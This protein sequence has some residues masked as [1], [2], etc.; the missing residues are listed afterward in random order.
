[1][2]LCTIFRLA[3]LAH[4][5]AFSPSLAAPL[6]PRAAVG[7]LDDVCTAAYAKAHL[8]ANPIGIIIDTNSV[9]ATAVKNYTV[10]E[11]NDYPAATFDFCKVTLSYS[12]D[13]G[14]AGRIITT[15]LQ[16]WLPQPS[17]F[18]N[19]WLSTGGGGLAINSGDRSLPG[20]VMRGAV[21]GITD[22]G[23]GGFDKQ[24]DSTFLRANG[25]VNWDTVYMFGYQAH[26]ELAVIGKAFTKTFFNMG[27]TTKLY[28]YYEGCSEGGR[29]GWSQVQRFGDQFDGAAIG[30]PAFRYGFQQA[31][32]LFQNLVEVNA[33]YFPPPCEFAAIVN[34]TIEFCDPLDGKTD[35]LVA[36]SDLCKLK[37]DM[38][39]VIGRPYDC[40]A[41]TGGG[42]GGGGAGGPGGPPPTPTPAQ[43]GTVSA[44]AVKIAT[45]ILGGL[46]DSSGK[47]VYFPYQ[48]AAQFVDGATQFDSATQKW[49]LSI[50]GLGGEWITRFL[51]HTDTSTLASLDGVTYDTLK[52]WMTLGTKMYGDSLQ[53]DD[54]DLTPFHTAGGKVIHFHGEADDSI[55]AASSVRYWESVRSTM[56]PTKTT[57]Q[58]SASLQDW[59]K[60]FIVPGAVHCGPSM[61]QPNSLWPQ[62]ALDSII[63]WVEKGAAP[64][65]LAGKVFSGA[66]KGLVE[67]IC[68]WPFRPLWSGNNSTMKCV[69]D[70]ASWKSWQYDLKGVLFPVA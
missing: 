27:G 56:Y 5:V 49:K 52:Q 15:Q 2:R 59:Y 31:N 23:F 63:D 61:V 24:V 60:L 26:H 36:R 25:T 32:H 40:A 16:F 39:S 45:T 43:K 14:A 21:A 58:S 11:N 48:F 34:A 6:Q 30:A 38:K 7:T 4:A 29:E 9:T 68:A 51:E 54:A 65:T 17:E 10:Q 66:N 19:R 3:T 42:G 22:G 47:Q 20:G 18:N 1:M 62:G 67:P 55:P 35:G 12:H 69:Q 28:S 53:T 33:S 37:F 44:Q 46:K 8:P 64:A 13:A 70:Q 57:A 50:S 41:V